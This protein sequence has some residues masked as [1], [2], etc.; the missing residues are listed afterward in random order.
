MRDMLKNEDGSFEGSLVTSLPPELI[1]RILSCLPGKDIAN[2]AAACRSFRLASTIESVW[3]ARCV[4]EYN[5][6]LPDKTQLSRKT[7]Y[8]K[9][10]Y[11]YGHLLGIWLTDIGAYGGLLQVKVEGDKLVGIEWHAP[12]SPNIKDALRKVILFSIE[13]VDDD[14]VVLCQKGKH[15]PHPCQLEMAPSQNE[16]KSFY[17]KC[18]KPECHGKSARKAQEFR[19][20]LQ[21]ETGTT[22]LEDRHS[23]EMHLMKFL[24]LREYQNTFQHHMTTF[25]CK[26]SGIVIQPG[27]FTGTY[28]AHGLELIML[29]YDDAKTKATATKVTGDPNVPAGKITFFCEMRNAIELT[30]DDQTT[31]NQVQQAV[32]SSPSMPLAELTPQPFKLPNDMSTLWMEDLNERHKDLPH[33]CKARFCA[34]GQVAGH[35][36]TH[37]SYISGHWIIFNEN[38]FGFL[39]F[40]LL[41]FSLFHR[42][43]D[44]AF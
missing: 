13:V 12:V 21:E 9:I 25:P 18:L 20:W 1:A 10:L 5:L 34:K 4:A 3:Q 41:S 7:L 6:D 39:W 15:G 22:H 23:E 31:M 44:P 40:E 27:L 24:H 2:A 29:S 17:S 19:E 28:S 32:P 38:L 30:D 42:V 16:K 14:V 36:F 37:P 8:T 11:K 33:V 26:R 35:G 43:L